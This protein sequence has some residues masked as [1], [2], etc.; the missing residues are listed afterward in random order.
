V[1]AKSREPDGVVLSVG[2]GALWAAALGTWLI[3]PDVLASHHVRVDSV[4][5]WLVLTTGLAL[6]FAVSGLFLGFVGAIVPILTETIVGRFRNRAWAYGLLMGPVLAIECVVET[7]LIH[8]TAYGSLAGISRYTRDIA[9][10]FIVLVLASPLLV[11]L[12]RAVVTRSRPTAAVLAW[13]LSGAVLLGIVALEP[14]LKAPS[15]PAVVSLE[16]SPGAGEVP[17]LFIGLDGATWRVLQPAIERGTAPTFKRLVDTGTHGT[18]DALWPPYW[19]SA[20]WAGI[21]TGQPQATTGVYE[22]L[23]GTGNGLPAFQI[24]LTP[25]LRLAPFF[26]LRASLQQAG[27]I[28]FTPPPR[29]LLHAKP[30]WQLLTE[31]GVDSAVVRFRFTYPPDDQAGLVVSDWAGHDEWETVGVRRPMGDDTVAPRARAGELLAPFRHEGP[32]DPDLFSRLLP[33]PVPAIPADNAFDPID[34]LRTAADIDDRTFAVSESILRSNPKQPFFAV[35]IGGL[36]AVEHAFWQ[37]RFPG[38]FDTNLPSEQDVRRL[39]PVIDRYVHYVD[40]RLNRLL[41]HYAVPPNIVIVS[42]HGHGATTF[43]SNWRGWHTKEGMFVAAGPTI[44]HRDAPISVS[45]FDVVPTLA[46][47]KGFRVTSGVNGN[48]ALPPDLSTH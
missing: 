34:A 29:E 8:R 7:L 36:D 38:D 46:A 18:I 44:P 26:V 40:E 31:H 42:D 9:I 15:P 39:G 5:P 47:L 22:D 10:V 24:P 35:Y 32:L 12:Y 11:W 21:L 1:S 30:V 33:G 43:Q 45:Y 20:A 14:F 3:A 19:S 41:L 2:W 23:A 28:R 27:V 37:Y 17:L 25:T 48:S 13:A 4:G 16:R 6:L